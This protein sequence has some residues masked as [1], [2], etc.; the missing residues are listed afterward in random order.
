MSLDQQPIQYGLCNDILYI[1][2]PQI[3]D[4]KSFTFERN[5]YLLTHAKMIVKAVT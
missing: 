3:V 1:R 2:T 4:L 5:S